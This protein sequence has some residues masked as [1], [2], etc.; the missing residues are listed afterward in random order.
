M[1]AES[2]PI[3]LYF[4]KHLKTMH[5]ILSEL[6]LMSSLNVNI[7]SAFPKFLSVNVLKVNQSEQSTLKVRTEYTCIYMLYS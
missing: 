1:C 5:L 4:I 6:A 7:R 2:V 3:K